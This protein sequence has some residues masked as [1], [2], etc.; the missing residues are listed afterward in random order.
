M[1]HDDIVQLGEETSGA[2]PFVE[3]NGSLRF[4]GTDDCWET[5]PSAPTASVVLVN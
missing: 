3:K 2:F 4:S 5:H 1:L